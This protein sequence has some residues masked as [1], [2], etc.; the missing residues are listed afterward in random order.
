MNADLDTFPYGKF[1]AEYRHI[2]NE[3]AEEPFALGAYGRPEVVVVPSE[4]YRQLADA[5]R[6]LDDISRTMPILLAAAQAGVAFP[7]ETLAALGYRPAFDAAK[8]ADFI[9]RLGVGATH[10]EDGQPLQQ[11]SIALS[12]ETVEE[13][14]EELMYRDAS[15]RV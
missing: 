15:P 5:N 14:D 4:L 8:L 11:S 3:H 10:G 2:I 12:H 1:R 6:R 13:D 9:N 7:S